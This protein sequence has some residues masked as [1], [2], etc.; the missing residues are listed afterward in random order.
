MSVLSDSI[1]QFIRDLIQEEKQVDLQR[2][3]LAEYFRCAPSQINY[4]LATRFTI[5]RGYKIESRRGGGGYIRVIRL[6]IDDNDYLF[7]LLTQR[8][9]EALSENTARQLVAY[10]REQRIVDEKGARL[11]EAAVSDKALRLPYPL[12]DQVRASVMKSMVLTLFD[13]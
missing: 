11:I 7:Q 12:K 6:N 3:E 4:V 5:D 2:N 9:G 13:Q 1:E 8:I 10:M